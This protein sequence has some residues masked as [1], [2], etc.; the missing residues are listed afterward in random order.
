[1]VPSKDLGQIYIQATTYSL[2][3]N[4]VSASTSLKNYTIKIILTTIN[5]NVCNVAFY[6]YHST[7][8]NNN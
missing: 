1:L 2:K 5:K 6:T 7:S 8:T 3:L 4:E